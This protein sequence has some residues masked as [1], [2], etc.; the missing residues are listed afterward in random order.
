VEF[1]IIYGQ[2]ISLLD[3]LLDIGVEMKILEK[4]GTWYNYG[5]ERLGHGRE[6]AKR[7]LAEHP[8]LADEIEKKVREGLGLTRQPAGKQ[9]MAADEVPAEEN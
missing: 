5:D 3:E 6:N 7:Y 2:G 4:S 1:D 8:Q 9:T